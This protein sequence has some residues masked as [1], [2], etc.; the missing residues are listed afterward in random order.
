MVR[1]RVPFNG[2][3][4][5]CAAAVLGLLLLTSALAHGQA[6]TTATLRGHVEDPSGAV[7]PGVTITLINQGTKATQTTVTDGRGQYLFAGL[8]PGTYDVRA[9]LSGFKAFE[10]KAL[11]LSPN[12]TRGLDIR[13]EVGA[14]T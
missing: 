14:Q 5:S 2:S 3:V 12:D 10:Q 7:L 8:F 9:E 6:S 13:L 1:S 11:T 4:I